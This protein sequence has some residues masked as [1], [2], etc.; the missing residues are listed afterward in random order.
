VKT[1]TT[2]T[3][4]FKRIHQIVALLLIVASGHA[5]LV[6]APAVGPK[7]SQSQ[8]A[9]AR[10]TARVVKLPFFDDFSTTKTDG[11]PDVSL[12]Q[13]GG[14]VF[15]SNT[16]TTDHPTTN[17]VAFDGVDAKGNP[18]NFSSPKAEGP[19]DSLT[20]QPIDMSGLTPVTD[21]IYFSFYWRAKGL[22]EKPDPTDT[23]KLQFLDVSGKWRTVWNSGGGAIVK[24][25]GKDTTRTYPDKFTNHFIAIDDK[26]FLYSGFQFRF[27]AY[28][29]ISGRFDTWYLD[30]IY[31]GTKRAI[32]RRVQDVACRLP[33]TPFL[34]RYSAMPIKQY[35]AKPAAETADSVLTNVF[36]LDFVSGNFTSHNVSIGDKI[37]GQVFQNELVTS[38]VIFPLGNQNR[39]IKVKPLPDLKTKEMVIVSKVVLNTSDGT[40]PNISIPGVNLKQNDTIVGENVL[41]NYYAYDDGTAEYTVYMNKTFGRTAVRFDLN[42]PDTIVA[43]QLNI[44]PILTNIEGQPFTILVWDDDNGKPGN[45]IAQQ[46]FKVKYPANRNGFTN[47]EFDYGVPVRNTVY[48]GWLQI[49]QDYIGVGLDKNYKRENKIF[50]NTSREWVAYSDTKKD[51]TS[52]LASVFEGVPMLRVVVGSKILPPNLRPLDKNILAT[53]PTTTDNWAIYPN[54]TNGLLNWKGEGVQQV[55]VMGLTGSVILE[56]KNIAQKSVD[57]SELPAG[58]YIIRLSNER[59]SLVQK[60]LKQ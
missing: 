4:I 17:V 59:K 41:S 38:S 35:F 1:Q 12:W 46:S 57:L 49:S 21:A 42:Q 26:A 10:T 36:N 34:K 37:S 58:Q 54:P 11:S 32:T 45:I 28:G 53:D 9:N 48:V 39:G 40:D 29:R 6:I 15:V 55:T 33:V 8:V 47:F 27:L 22:S 7:L 31:L 3:G 19:A 5:Q 24:V 30:Y 23:L 51:S 60:V 18:Y 14:G 2:E 50:T 56:T 13:K 20:S 16:L 44:N 25:T 52:T 43:V